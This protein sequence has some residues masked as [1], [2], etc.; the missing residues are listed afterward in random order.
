MDRY[1]EVILYIFLILLL[2]LKENKLNNYFVIHYCYVVKDEKASYCII[3]SICIKLNMQK[4][5]LL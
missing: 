2:S 5:L 4:K 1:K 3:K